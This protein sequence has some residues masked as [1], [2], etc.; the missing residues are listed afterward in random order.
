MKHFHG[1]LIF[2]LPLVAAACAYFFIYNRNASAEKVDEMNPVKKNSSSY[3]L[4]EEPFEDTNWKSRGWYDGPDMQITVKEHIPG[5][6]HSCVWHWKKAGDIKPEGGGARV[7]FTPVSSVTLSFY[8]KHSDNWKWTG[9]NWHPH[10]FHFLTTGDDSLVGPAYTHLTFYIEAVNGV[11]R[12]AIQDGKNIDISRIGKN[13]VGVSEN[14]SVAGG[15]GDSDGYGNLGY[16]PNNGV[17]WNGKHWE[18]EKRYFSDEPGTCFKGDWHHVKVKLR[19]NSVKEGIGIR[20]G[21]LQYW[22]DDELIMDCHDVVYR[23]GKHPD[24]HIN[25]F[26]MAPYYGP[27]VPHEQWIWIDDLE[28]TTD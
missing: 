22:F 25:Q 27:G 6:G 2:F 9:V 11:P 17:Y 20:D 28:I 15:N 21:V 10:E 13:L 26:L 24:M 4:F 16:Y 3:T 18:P 14:R 1:K 8:I 5:S 12:I 7:L 19:L 23:T